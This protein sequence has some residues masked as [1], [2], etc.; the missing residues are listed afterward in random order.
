[1]CADQVLAAKLDLSMNPRALIF[2]LLVG[3]SAPFAA[4]AD[5]LPHFSMAIF[6]APDNTPA[7]AISPGNPYTFSIPGDAPSSGQLYFRNDT[8]KVLTDF[9]IRLSHIFDIDIYFVGPDGPP[10]PPVPV[11]VPPE[12]S[13][14]IARYSCN[15]TD[16]CDVL[17]PSGDVRQYRQIGPGENML[18]EFATVPG[19]D[20]SRLIEIEFTPSVAPEPHTWTLILAGFFGAGAVLRRRRAMVE[21]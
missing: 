19:S 2:M 15:N 8:L 17:L 6:N 16:Y 18:V 7:I 10:P 1:M 21:A 13:E 5:N 11:T 12:G 4:R 14:V 9:H 20:P 3:L